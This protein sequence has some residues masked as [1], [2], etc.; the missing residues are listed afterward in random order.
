MIDAAD[1]WVLVCPGSSGS[2]GVG[3]HSRKPTQTLILELAPGALHSGLGVETA[4]GDTND[5]GFEQGGD[6]ALAVS[7]RRWG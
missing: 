7:I 3:I 5:G 1:V 6:P 4:L 2:L